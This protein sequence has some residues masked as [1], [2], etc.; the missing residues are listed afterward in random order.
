MSKLNWLLDL[1]FFFSQLF[2]K[3][4]IYWSRS[5]PSQRLLIKQGQHTIKL[6]WHFLFL[7]CPNILHHGQR[8]CN[9]IITPLT[10]LT[11]YLTCRPD[12]VICPSGPGAK[13]ERRCSVI[14]LRE[15]QHHQQRRK[16]TFKQRNNSYRNKLG[17]IRR[18]SDLWQ[19]RQGVNWVVSQEFLLIIGEL[20]FSSGWWCDDCD[21]VW[22]L[23][24]LV[25]WVTKQQESNRFV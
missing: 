21:I 10:Y 23:Q 5:F 14:S 12:H 9:S 8:E 6:N 17:D 18:P 4:K 7:L 25:V 24:Q 2:N 22:S 3:L 11:W 19:G 15:N 13:T 16:Y 20:D 1:F